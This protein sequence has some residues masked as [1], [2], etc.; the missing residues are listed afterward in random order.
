MHLPFG[1]PPDREALEAAAALI[2]RGGVVDVTWP[3]D[4]A[5][6]RRHALP[7]AARGRVPEILEL[8]LARST[9]LRRD[10]VAWRHEVTR[11]EDG[12]L[13]VR[14]YILKRG[15][16]DVLAAAL[17][18]AGLAL[19]RL[20]IGA[21]GALAPFVDRT[22]EL[23][24]PARFWRW[25]NAALLA[26]CLGLAFHLVSAPHFAR[27]GALEAVAAEADTLRA[28][29]VMLR[30]S[31][32][33]AAARHDAT[34]ALI[35][36]FAETPPAIDVLREL[37]A[38]LPDTVWLS[39]LQISDTG[40]RF[41][42]FARGSAAELVID[43]GTSRLLRNPRLTGPVSVSPGDGAERF[44]IAVDLGGAQ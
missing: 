41:S 14:Q 25:S 12:G 9:P 18:R 26:A 40:A 42:G 6:L 23:A 39:E 32:D 33:E 37:T 13:A 3:A 29:A 7:A 27:R 28:R 43:L 8:E 24:H 44:E 31:V 4:A 5:L 1:L 35:R 2:G 30:Q 16:I 34:A 22:R 11:S 36:V 21:P 10:Q 17:G 15:D 20:E 19:R 38:R